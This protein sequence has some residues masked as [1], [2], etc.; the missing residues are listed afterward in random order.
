MEI[1]HESKSTTVTKEKL[2]YLRGRGSTTVV[3]VK[4]F[5]PFLNEFGNSKL[6]ELY[7]IF[8]CHHHGTTT[9]TEV[10]KFYF[11]HRGSTAALPADDLTV[12][13]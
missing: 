1:V 9:A 6:F 7:L 2:H 3:A 12:C 10:V 11:R 5:L 13:F 8:Y 4:K